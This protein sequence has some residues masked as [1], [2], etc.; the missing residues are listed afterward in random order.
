MEPNMNGPSRAVPLLEAR[1]LTVRFGEVTALD[2]LDL[3]VPPG[4]V[5]AILGPNGAGKS[6]FV[7][8]VATLVQPGERRAACARH[9][10]RARPDQG[11]S[12]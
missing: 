1:G 7:R 4:E 11:A 8:T 12:R 2:G 9:R 3:N 10:C 6:T 5:L